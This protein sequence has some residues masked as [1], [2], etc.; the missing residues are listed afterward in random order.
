[1]TSPSKRQTAPP[2]VQPGRPWYAVKESGALYSRR[3]V[4]TG[5]SKPTLS[6]RAVAA[7]PSQYF[8]VAWLRSARLT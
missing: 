2:I 7:E 4:T 1:M 3:P 5:P 8:I 6:K